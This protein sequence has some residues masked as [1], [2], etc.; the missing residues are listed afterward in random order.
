MSKLVVT[1]QLAG[2][3]PVRW[4]SAASQSNARPG[5]SHWVTSKPYSALVV[6]QRPPWMVFGPEAIV[7]DIQATGGRAPFLRRDLEALRARTTVNQQL[8][9]LFIPTFL[10]HEGQAGQDGNVKTVMEFVG[11]RLA[12]A[13][14]ALFTAHISKGELLME[15]R[16]ATTVEDFDRM[17]RQITETLHGLPHLAADHLGDI[18][19]IDTYWRQLASRFPDMLQYVVSH[20]QIGQ[21]RRHLVVSARLPDKAAHNLVLA[22]EL[23]QSM[24]PVRSA[25]RTTI[26]SQIG[27]IEELL[28]ARISL[29]FP[30]QSLD[31]AL[32][33]LESVIR[34][35]LRPSLSVTI[36]V[37]GRHLQLEGIT[38]NQQITDFRATDV[39]VADVLTELVLHANP[40]RSVN[41]P[42][43]VN[44]KLVWIAEPG[45]P[46]K[47]NAV[48][49]ITTRAGAAE[50]ELQ[51]PKVFGES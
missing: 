13:Q 48:I 23:S 26:P 34:D 8:G 2:A 33:D 37:D 51:L 3:V 31:Q 39:T 36:R 7:R 20:S 18:D 50:S 43:D 38:R 46:S 27:S 49:R 17:R 24:A 16:V 1:V 45:T 25:S 28:A 5:T 6:E 21:D 11:Q 10:V 12:G 22:T 47:G 40:D 15:L 44:Q 29:S 41:G 30:R 4:R 42:T 32:A 35:Q 19:S 9:A 14:A